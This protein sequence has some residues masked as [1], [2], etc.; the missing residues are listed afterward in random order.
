MM[1]VMCIVWLCSASIQ[2]I[3]AQTSSTKIITNKTNAI[4][5]TTSSMILKQT[6]PIFLSITRQALVST[7]GRLRKCKNSGEDTE[8]GCDCSKTAFQGPQCERPIGIRPQPNINV[9]FILPKILLHKFLFSLNGYSKQQNVI[10]ITFREPLPEIAV[11]NLRIE[12]EH[13]TF[14][15]YPEASNEIGKDRIELGKTLPHVVDNDESR[16]YLFNLSMQFHH[17]YVNN[18]TSMNYTL[19]GK[20]YDK[21]TLP[22]P[23]KKVNRLIRYITIGN[24][25]GCLHSFSVNDKYFPLR[26]LRYPTSSILHLPY[27][28]KV[29]PASVDWENNTKLQ[30][31]EHIPMIVAKSKLIK[32]ITFATLFLLIIVFIAIGVSYYNYLKQRSR[33]HRSARTY[34]IH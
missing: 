9:T 20:V 15:W 27:Q 19:N 32:Y 28:A 31:D 25:I 1:F 12:K 30:C 34:T 7:A 22:V 5:V 3:E 8:D 17:S 11:F 23:K 10:L 33:S 21:R 14:H 6:T 26:L 29:I 18:T 4:N 16:I 13:L 24:F 2:P